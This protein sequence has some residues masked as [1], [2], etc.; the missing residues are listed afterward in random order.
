[1]AHARIDDVEVFKKYKNDCPNMD[2]LESR[3][4]CLPLNPKI[5]IRDVV[6]ICKIIKSA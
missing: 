4:V 5:T 1:M 6:Q 2:A 3:Y